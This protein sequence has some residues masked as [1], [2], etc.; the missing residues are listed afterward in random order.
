MKIV[1]QDFAG[2]PFPLQLSRELARQGNEVLH[3]YFAGNNTPKGSIRQGPDDP[4]GWQIRGL[5]LKTDFQKHSVIRRR[6]CDI[7]YGRIAAEY[8]RDFQPHLVLSANAP[9]DAQALLLKEAHTVGARFVFW[10]QDIYSF[11]IRF[12][13]KNKRMPLSS[14]IANYYRRLEQKLLR[15][16]DAIVCIAPEFGDVLSEWDIAS[17]KMFV[18]ENWA[19]LPDIEPLPQANPW[20]RRHGLEGK[21]CFVYSGTLGLK[22]KPELLLRLAEKFRDEPDVHIVVVAEGAGADWLRDCVSMSPLQN[23]SLLPLQPYSEVPQVLATASVLVAILDEDCGAFCVPSKTLAY[24]CTKRPLLVAAPE[25][26]LATALLRRC[27]AGVAVSS[28][29]PNAFVEAA[30]RL[31]LDESLRNRCARSGY[32]Y[33]LASFQIDHVCER[34]QEVF[35]FVGA[36]LGPQPRNAS[37]RFVHDVA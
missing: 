2:H 28:G 36:G 17:D 27:G 16:S 9:L 21:F 30:S 23:L 32:E 14:L 15:A 25:A 35:R 26:N 12:V 19:P 3:L 11:A 5:E 1:L 10:L 20:A 4:A 31:R 6:R 22:H 8:I 13:L 18:I 29:D 37:K 33:A 34:F 7:A 24:L